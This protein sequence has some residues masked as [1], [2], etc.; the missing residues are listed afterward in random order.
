MRVKLNQSMALVV[1]V[2][3]KLFPHMNSKEKL[4]DNCIKLIKG[5]KLLEVSFLLNEQYPKGLG[6][7]HGTIKELLANDEVFEK[8][9]FSCCKTDKTKEA[10]KN[11]KKNL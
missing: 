7:T 9:T 5:L 1:D 10:I 8:F 11:T 6:Q 4:L 3:E 2:Q